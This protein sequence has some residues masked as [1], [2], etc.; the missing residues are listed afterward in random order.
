MPQSINRDGR[1]AILPDGSPPVTSAHRETD[2]YV[3]GLWNLIDDL[4]LESEVT[5]VISLAARP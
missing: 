2:L 5:E 3:V 4:V 1:R